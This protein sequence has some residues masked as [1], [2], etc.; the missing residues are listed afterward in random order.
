M[1]K[2]IQIGSRFTKENVPE[3]HWHTHDVKGASERGS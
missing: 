1:M 3:L 2:L